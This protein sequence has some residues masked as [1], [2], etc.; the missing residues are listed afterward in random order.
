M[1]GS[2]A[3]TVDAASQIGHFYSLYSHK[4]ID[5]NKE[6]LLVHW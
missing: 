6:I 5:Y 1:K 2:A 4:H 3:N